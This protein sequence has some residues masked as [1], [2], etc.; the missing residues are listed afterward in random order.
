MITSVCRTDGVREY[1]RT[2]SY[3]DD[4]VAG[5]IACIECSGTGWWDYAPYAVAGGPCVEC[6]GTGRVWVGLR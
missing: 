6:K 5:Q 1:A 2:A 4:A 3:P